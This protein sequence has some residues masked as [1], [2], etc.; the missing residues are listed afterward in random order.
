MNGKKPPDTLAGWLLATEKPCDIYAIGFQELDLTAGA[1]IAGETAKGKLWEQTILKTLNEVGPY[2]LLMS[3]QLVGM[4]L[5]IA[6][7][8]DQIKHVKHA[9]DCVAPVGILGVMGNKGAVSIR[10]QFHD[11]TFCFVN[12]HLSAHQDQVLRRNQDFRDISRLIQFSTISESTSLLSHSA[13][14]A[15]PPLSVASSRSASVSNLRASAGGRLSS[16]RT[17][18]GPQQALRPIRTPNSLGSDIDMWT[19]YSHH[20]LFWLGDLNYRI[21]L[22]SD[23]LRRA[24]DQADWATLYSADQLTIQ[25]NFGAIYEGFSE[26]PIAFAPTY[27]YDNLSTQYDTSEKARLPAWTDRVLW[28]GKDIALQAYRRHELLTSD[29]RPVSA[30]FITTIKS[31]IVQ[32]RRSVY[33][34]LVRKID[35]IENDSI[36]DVRVSEK[37]ISFGEVEYMLPSTRAI[38]ITNIGHVIA[39]YRFVAKTE[40]NQICKPWLS[41]SPQ[42]GVLVPGEEQQLTITILVGDHTAG[43]LTMKTEDLFDI[44]VLHLDRGKDEYLVISGAFLPSCYGAP[45]EHLVRFPGP[46]RST[47]PC[48]EQQDL[49]PLPKEIWILVDFLSN[50]G[51]RVPLLFA[52]PGIPEENRTIRN[53][54]D[55]G[56]PLEQNFSGSIH[57]VAA[58]LIELLHS[59]PTSIVP[60]NLFDRCV[61][62]CDHPEACFDIIRG[63]PP[64]SYNTFHYLMAFFREFL[65]QDP[66]L[67]PSHLANLISTAFLRSNSDRKDQ[68][69]SLMEYRSIFLVHFLS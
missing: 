58:A 49:L 26:A 41:I 38:S 31:V 7:H 56:L 40:A 43:P 8:Q 50:H 59:F 28:K 42:S 65:K 47:K 52:T 12:S 11:S 24:I 25:K 1:L 18:S 64:V 34:E 14:P 66:S 23:V 32:K 4:L 61:G 22:P 29:H 51:L 30:T 67:R 37:E 48:D 27:K 3:K 35:K 68:E 2:Q 44:L 57:S 69:P 15:P 36:P 21:D 16:E 45:I 6:V 33:N 17:P 5:V 53:M 54:L 63:L 9:R 46:I 10:F 19:I 39:R 60:Q 20:H 13:H 55:L 62:N